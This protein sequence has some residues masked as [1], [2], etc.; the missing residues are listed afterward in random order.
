MSPKMSLCQT[1]STNISNMATHL[2]S[3]RPAEALLFYATGLIRQAIDLL[4]H[5]VTRDEQL[6]AES[7]LIPGGSVGKHLRS[8]F[9]H[10]AP[11]PDSLVTKIL[12]P[13]GIS[14]TTSGFFS[15][16]LEPV[17]HP[18]ERSTMTF[19]AETCPWRRPGA[20]HCGCSK[21]SRLVWRN[22]TVR[23]N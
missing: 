16:M 18:I 21:T 9:A 6:S 22:A 12:P 17:S 5:G 10:R 14:M 19:A 15:I 20:R 4:R 2:E 3:P 23:Q 8:V 1:S 7:T 11:H 13:K